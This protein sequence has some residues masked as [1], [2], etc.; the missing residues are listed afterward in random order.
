MKNRGPGYLVL[1][2]YFSLVTESPECS[3]NLVYFSLVSKAGRNGEKNPVKTW[4][5][6][7]YVP[8]KMCQLKKTTFTMCFEKTLGQNLTQILLECFF[9]KN[10]DFGLFFYHY[11]SQF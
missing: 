10:N 8:L 11:V 1:V 7:H 5:F 2:V 9:Q 6:Y 4:F 3:H